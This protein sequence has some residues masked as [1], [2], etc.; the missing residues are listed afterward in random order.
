MTDEYK[1]IT[2]S[3]PWFTAQLA[4]GRNFDSVRSQYNSASPLL[5]SL[6]NAMDTPDRDKIADLCDAIEKAF[7][8]ADG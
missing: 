4:Q 8:R 3:R 7:A 2:W 6:Y 5:C 1:L